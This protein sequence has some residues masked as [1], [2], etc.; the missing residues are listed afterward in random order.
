VRIVGRARGGLWAQGG[1][2]CVGRL[3]LTRQSNQLRIDP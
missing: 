3:S 1:R 2:T